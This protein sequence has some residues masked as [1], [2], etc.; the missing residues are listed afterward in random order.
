[1]GGH[2][3]KSPTISQPDLQRLIAAADACNRAACAPLV[4]VGTPHFEALQELSQTIRRTII[5]LTG[6]EPPWVHRK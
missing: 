4:R 2:K 3:R 5:S 1:M 6:E